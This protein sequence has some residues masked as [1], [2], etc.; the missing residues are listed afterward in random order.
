MG[1][2]S[3]I[4]FREVIEILLKEVIMSFFFIVRQFYKDTYAN[5][6][7]IRQICCNL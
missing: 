3:G 7:D 4:V 6:N 1:K 2:K 5:T